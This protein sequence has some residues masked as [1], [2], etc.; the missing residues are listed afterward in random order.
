LWWA[1]L[2]G[3]TVIEPPKEPGKTAIP[4]TPK[5]N[6]L[7]IG[8]VAVPVTDAV[9][10]RAI[11]PNVLFGFT[12]PTF[13][14]ATRTAFRHRLGH[15]L[16]RNALHGSS[17]NLDDW[18]THDT[19]RLLP[20]LAVTVEPGAA[21]ESPAPWAAAAGAPRALEQAPS[22]GSPPRRR[23]SDRVQVRTQIGEHES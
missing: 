1:T 11:D 13:L 5:V 3:V 22:C 17:V 15:S 21:A 7:E 20:G 14:P 9:L 18:E 19:R 16:G 23:G 2:G 12:T 4:R 8:G 6:S 10:T